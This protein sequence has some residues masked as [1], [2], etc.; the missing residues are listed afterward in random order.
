MTILK[1][2]PLHQNSE[3]YGEDLGYYI[4][5]LTIRIG[6]YDKDDIF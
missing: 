3:S 2:M 1:S 4:Y 6:M 5:I